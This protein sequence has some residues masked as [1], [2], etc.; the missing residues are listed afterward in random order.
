MIS[1]LSP[2]G[3]DGK[4]SVCYE[5]DPGSTPGSGKPPGKGL[6]AH[7]SIL[8]LENFMDREAW[9]APVHGITESDMTD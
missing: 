6:A 2:A 7:S 9:Q 4:E 8:A 3:S 1:S 5:G